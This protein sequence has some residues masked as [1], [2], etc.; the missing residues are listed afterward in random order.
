M[1]VHCLCDPD[2]WPPQVRYNWCPWPG[3]TK[4]KNRDERGWSRHTGDKKCLRR[5]QTTVRLCLNSQKKVPERW[6][7]KVLY[8][9]DIG[10]ETWLDA[11]VEPYWGAR[12]RTEEFDR[13]V[14]E[15]LGAT[16][17]GSGRWRQITRGNV[18]RYRVSY[19]VWSRGVTV[20]KPISEDTEGIK[21]RAP[22]ATGGTY[23][24]K[25]TLV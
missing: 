7:L 14:D 16:L 24:D 9:T 22:G 1:S 12:P 4:K 21:T 18:G 13:P 6:N 23:D 5:W 8:R 17:R 20:R 19:A 2:R 10:K 25:S 15:E 3:L 11:T